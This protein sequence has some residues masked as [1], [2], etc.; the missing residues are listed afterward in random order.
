MSST[1]DTKNVKANPKTI[2]VTG[3]AGFIGSHLCE[4]L[5][6]E[7]GDGHRDDDTSCAYYRIVGVDSMTDYYDVG[8][9]RENVA[10]I[11]RSVE[12]HSREQEQRDARNDRFT[13]LEEDIRTTNAIDVHRPDVVIHLA[14][15]A[16]VRHSLTSAC[17][18][19]DVNVGAQVRLLAECVRCGVRDFLY[20]SSSSVYGLS[21][22][23]PY[24]EDARTDTPNSPYACT[25][26]AME[27]FAGM[28]SRLFSIRTVGLRFFTV[29]GPRGRPDMSPHKFLTAIDE[30][31]PLRMYG[32][33]NAIYRDFTFVGDIVEGIRQML[34]VGFDQL[35]THQ[36]Q[37]ERGERERERETDREIDRG[38]SQI[39]NLGSGRLISM[40]AFIS[41]CSDVVGKPAVIVR[42]RAQLGDV[43]VTLAS[44]SKAE[45]ACGYKPTC[46][47]RTGLHEMLVDI[48]SRSRAMPPP[49]LDADPDMT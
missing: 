27:D 12:A 43:P 21:R 35:V 18:Y 19:V 14:S 38:G 44:V 24:S 10:A 41:A 6:R 1:T 4:R 8:V 34:S 32:D 37:I 7:G 45:S 31:K 42:E 39:F 30:Q 2:L 17:E 47:L 20:A 25:K 23:V 16:G 26:K 46:P 11:H 48:R 33:P 40:S 29:Y 28:Y 15:L 36:Y 22:D 49:T 5:L 9:K 3:C 13:F